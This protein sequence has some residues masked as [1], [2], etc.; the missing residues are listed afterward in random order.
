MHFVDRSTNGTIRLDPS[1]VR[2]DAS[3]KMAAAIAWGGLVVGLGLSPFADFLSVYA[4]KGAGVQHGVD[5][6]IS[7]VLRGMMTI[8]LIVCLIYGSRTSIGGL[9]QT[10]AFA[11]VVCATIGSYAFGMLVAREVFEQVVFA[12]KVFTFFVYPAAMMMLTN[13]RLDQVQSV[14]FATLMAYGLSII[15]GA[16]LSIELFRS[17]QADVQIRSGYK[18]IIYAQNEA[19]ALVVTATAFG[20]LH[21]LLRGWTWRSMSLVGCMIVASSLTGTKGAMLGV[22]GVTCVYFFARFNAIKA[23]WY[24]G[25]VLTALAI[26][27]ISAYFFVPAV[28]QAVELS[29]RY[30]EYRSGHTDD[31]VLLTL[32][33]SGRNLKLANVWTDVQANDY[34]ALLTG[35]HPVVRYMVEL[36][37]FDPLLAFGVPIFAIYTLA[38]SRTFIRRGAHQRVNRFAYLFFVVLIGMACTAGH[39]LGSA[40]VSPYLALIAVAIRR[41][42]PVMRGV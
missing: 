8:S 6:R 27:A 3:F 32:L 28:N 4:A 20:Y 9:R 42:V 12:L 13:R 36:D 30:F 16:S 19:A 31:D 29:L 18:G 5:A 33:L 38:L 26:A 10:A 39:V 34:I 15:I 23:S 22:I 24:A 25:L 11:F 41:A 21:A 2:T 14:A 35:G 17:Y 40:V 37:A 7:L 1:P